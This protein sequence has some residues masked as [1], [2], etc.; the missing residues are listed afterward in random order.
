[1]RDPR[2]DQ[3]W[4]IDNLITKATLVDCGLL[5]VEFFNDDAGLTSLDTE[6]FLD[7]RA[8]AGAFSLASLYSEN[9]AKKGLYPIKYRV[10]HTIYTMNVVTRVDPFTVT[11]VDPCENDATIL[12]VGLQNQAY[13]ITDTAKTYQMPEY[14]VKPTWCAITYTYTVTE[15]AG[16]G[17]ITFDPDQT[18]RTFTFNN[19]ADLAISGPS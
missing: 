14:V 17:V 13:T 6:I 11:I 15:A 18:V 1:M 5:T 7:D 10:Y 2:I 12:S 16:D 9:V 8:N 4:D 3:F 19:I